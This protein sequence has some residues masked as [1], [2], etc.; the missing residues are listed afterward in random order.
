MWS[1][2][3]KPVVPFQRSACASKPRERERDKKRKPI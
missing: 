2:S 1:W 3:K